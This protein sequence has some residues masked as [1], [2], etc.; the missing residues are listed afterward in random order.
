V[1]KPFSWSF[2]KYKNFEVCP[3]RH[4]EVDLAKNYTDSTEQL[5]WGNSVHKALA[6]ACSGKSPLPAT[7]TE[8]QPWV[9][10]VRAGPGELLVEQKYALTKD[11]QPTEYFGARAWYRGIGDVVRIDGPVGL[12]LDWKTGTPKHDSRQLMLLA[13]CIFAFHPEVK[14]VRTE[15]VWLKEDYTTPEIFDRDTI[16]NEWLPI[17]E[18]VKLM[19]R[20]ALN[21]DYPPKPGKLCANWC[22]VISCPF[23]G[24]RHS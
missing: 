8:Y 23:H 13:Q 21:V 4:Y 12:G 14:R 6:D 11:F 1:V 7:M 17:L 24:K 22:P 10:R 2:S 20:A 19:E 15:F 3:K 9:D 18:G 5:D 16:R